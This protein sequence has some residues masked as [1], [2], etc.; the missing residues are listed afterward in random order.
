MSTGGIGSV[1]GNRVF[2]ITDPQASVMVVERADFTINAP[3]T[4][5]VRRLVPNDI[6]DTLLKVFVPPR[7]YGQIADHLRKRRTVIV[8]GAPGTGRRSAALMALVES[9]D[10]GSGFRELPDDESDGVLRFDPEVI[11]PGER[12]V[13]DF[14]ADAR[15]LTPQV[16]AQL[17]AYRA[18]VAE[19]G[20]YLAIVLPATA[21]HT[22]IQAPVVE[23][24]RPDGAEVLR[25]HLAALGVPDAPADQRLAPHCA[26]DPMRELA[27]LADR[28]ARARADLDGGGTWE[29]WLTP[30]LNG[31]QAQ[32]GAV[33]AAV[34]KHRGGR[35]RALLLAAAVFEQATPEVVAL[36]SA[37]LLDLVDYPPDEEHRLDKPDLAQALHEL[38]ADIAGRRVRFATLTYAE[39]VRTH[40]WTA[41]PEL[42]PKLRRWIGQFLRD[43]RMPAEDRVAAAL[44][45]T[46][47]CLATDHPEDVKEVVD[48][49]TAAGAGEPLLAAAGAAL[50]RGLLD[51]RH[52]RWFRG[53]V[54]DWSRQAALPPALAGLLIELCVDTI[55]PVRPGQAL[56]RL[57][58]LA[59]HQDAGVAAEARA[60]IARLAEQDGYFARRLLHRVH[61]D[62][63]GWH[64]QPVDH[65]LFAVVADPALL[66]GAG[67]RARLRITE[68]R[69]RRLLTEAWAV[70]LTAGSAPLITS[71]LDAHAAAPERDALIDCL[72]DA[73]RGTPAAVALLYATARDWHAAA[74]TPDDARNRLRTA[75]QLR[76]A[77]MTV[78]SERTS[79]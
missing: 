75:A 70:A 8:T 33:A 27:A 11:E 7:G 76:K 51:D 54:Y 13:L 43:G 65:A 78:H 46:E 15:A 59:K 58:H 12:L 1:S 29:Q 32:A 63:S 69:T 23:I 26:G 10:A 19:R 66:F 68:P 64:P 45:F 14:S 22:E 62:L 42:R 71:W 18:E 44:R 72:A 38:D 77:C 49:W 37:R 67:G 30:A 55:A 36:A 79:Q 74:P 40:F 60:A 41:F 39:A 52:D 48:G 16:C 61:H 5:H 73:A 4:P 25:R 50:S 9:S 6:I 21:G 20:A 56:V 2:A 35:T 3:A 31:A 57:R 24:G 47:Q 17:R 53:Q 34:R 28:I